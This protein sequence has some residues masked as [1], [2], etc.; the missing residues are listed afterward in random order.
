M[1]DVRRPAALA[2]CIGD[3]PRDVEAGH[4]A[5]AGGTRARRTGRRELTVD[6]DRRVRRRAARH[7]TS[8]NR[9]ALRT[10]AGAARRC[11]RRLRSSASVRSCPS[12]SADA[13][14]SMTVFVIDSSKLEPRHSRSAPACSARTAA[15]ATPS[16]PR[17]SATASMSSASVMIDAV[18]AHRRRAGARSTRALSD[19]GCVVERVG[20]EVGGEDGVDAGLDR[21]RERHQLALAQRRHRRARRAPARGGCRRSCRRGRGSAWRTR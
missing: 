3:A 13:T 9:P 6:D 8:S 15:S 21:G 11:A 4:A 17:P 2:Q 10:S 1:I 16:M 7:R 20:D 12:S 14:R 19:T 5:G 18:E